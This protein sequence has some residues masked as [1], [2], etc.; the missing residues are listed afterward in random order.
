MGDAAGVLLI[1][2]YADRWP[3]THLTW[4]FSNALLHQTGVPTRVLLIARSADAWPAVRAAWPTSR[5]GQQ[6]T[7]SK[8]LLPARK[9]AGE[10]AAMFTAARDSFAVRYDIDDP[11]GSS[12][13]DLWMIR[14]WA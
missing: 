7:S 8:R 9:R 1:V 13:P 4:L 12:P 10:R 6:R 3:L 11:Y 14:T 2:D 5:P